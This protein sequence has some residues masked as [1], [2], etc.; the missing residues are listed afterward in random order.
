MRPRLNPIDQLK[1]ETTSPKILCLRLR[2][3]GDIVLTTPALSALKTYLP[4]S[5]IHYVVENPYAQLIEHHP[6]V[7]KAIIIPPKP[8]WG[9][10]L[11][12]IRLLRKEHYHI[13]IDFHGGPRAFLLTLATPA[14][15]KIGYHLPWKHRF[16][17]LTI[18]RGSQDYPLHSAENHL[19]LIKTLGLS[20]ATRP[21]LTLPQALPQ[22]KEKVTRLLRRYS[23]QKSEYLVLHIG[24]GNKFRHWGPTNLLHFLQIYLEDG[25]RHPLCLIGGPEDLDLAEYLFRQLKLPS[26][27]PLI[28]LVDQFSLRELY[29][30]FQQ[31]KL[32]IGPDSG[33]MHIAAAAGLPI[34]AYFGPTIPA[35]FGPWQCKAVILERKLDCRPC[36]QRKCLY[37]DF[38]CLRQ[39]SPEEVWAAVKNLLQEVVDRPLSPEENKG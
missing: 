24:A 29:Y 7:D 38:P 19:N 31:A 8:S 35:H 5:K 33:P 18:P 2:R 27:C 30:F 1:I 6:A 12:L 34:V 21:P 16:Y 37:S 20:P 28:N 26:P 4:E 11:S 9:E 22:E 15:L 13:I 32:F 36:R 14:P 10:F 25:W 23:L 39:I 17:D 3:I